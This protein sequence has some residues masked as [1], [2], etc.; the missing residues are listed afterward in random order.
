MGY[1]RRRAERVRVGARAFW[2]PL[3]AIVW[4]ATVPGCGGKSGVTDSAGG[5]TGAAGAAGNAGAT[6]NAGATGNAG[7]SAGT[8]G[9]T[10]LSC[11]SLAK[12]GGDPNG[13]WLVDPAVP[14]TSAPGTCAIPVVRPDN[15]CKGFEYFPASS[16]TPGIT[17]VAL[18]LPP[19]V[20]I[21]G[22][23]F[24]LN[25]DQ[26]YS[27]QLTSLGSAS[28]ELT[29]ACLTAHGANP[30]CA[31]LQSPLLQA[32]ATAPDISRLACAALPD[33]GCGCSRSLRIRLCGRGP[34]AHCRSKCS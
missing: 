9:D 10:S 32:T 14:V 34:V 19:V 30:T 23:D 22:A 25:S 24:Q 20:T 33:G 5:A 31:E 28:L 16:P 13:H 2:G 26:S 27:I 21:T 18:P 8:G 15:G 6:A 29:P 7:A 17:A 4:L 1:T 11:R 3:W 12:C